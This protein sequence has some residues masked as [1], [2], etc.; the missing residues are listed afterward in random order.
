MAEAVSRE[1]LFLTCITAFVIVII[2]IPVLDYLNV[3][4]LGR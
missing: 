2:W 4:P 3:I 1:T